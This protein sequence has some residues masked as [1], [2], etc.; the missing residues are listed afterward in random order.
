MIKHSTIKYSFSRKYRFIL[1]KQVGFFLGRDF[2]STIQEFSFS[3]E[4]KQV[5]LRINGRCLTIPEG[6]A[7]NGS[8][9]RPLGKW[10]IWWLGTPDCQATI[11]ASLLHDALYQFLDHPDF[12]Y[13]RE[14]CD[15]A[16]L[17]MMELGKFPLA[18]I[19]WSAVRTFGGL[20]R[21]ITK[22]A[23]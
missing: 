19:Y 9:P 13:S 4:D 7:W 16:F 6:Y 22:G 10:G 11:R 1:D 12:P 20:D 15:M 23:K 21:L 5:W 3:G 17:Q 14:Q 2:P 18:K 8:S